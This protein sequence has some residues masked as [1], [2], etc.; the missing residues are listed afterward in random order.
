MIS[1]NNLLPQQKVT[2]AQQKLGKGRGRRA[3]RSYCLIA[4]VFSSRAGINRRVGLLYHAPPIHIGRK[5]Y[6]IIGHAL[7]LSREWFVR[8]ARY[9]GGRTRRVLT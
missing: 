7:R 8:C 5:A 4:A 1:Q 2:A 3:K 9:S 6:S